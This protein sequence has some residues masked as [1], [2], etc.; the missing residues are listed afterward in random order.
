MGYATV[1]T[2]LA[3]YLAGIPGIQLLLRDAPS[4][5]DGANWSLDV[6]TTHGAVAFFHIDQSNE[7][8]ISLPA[9]T[10]QKEVNYTI[11][12]LIQ[13]QYLLPAQYEDAQTADEWVD[14]LDTI[15]DEVKKRIRAD[16]TAGTGI[17]GV[18]FQIGQ[19]PGD[20]AIEQDLPILDG[21]RTYSFTRIELHLTEIIVA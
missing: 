11:S 17:G 5:L 16:P 1:R 9:I 8:R 2:A 12:F 6:G 19:D 14:G 15:I 20:I 7:S 21:N 13:Y 10:G 4:F 18:I 3:S